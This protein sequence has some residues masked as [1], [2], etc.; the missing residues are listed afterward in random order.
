[1]ADNLKSAWLEV[2]IDPSAVFPDLVIVKLC[3]ICH[4]GWLYIFSS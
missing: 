2:S 3:S 1:L 4:W